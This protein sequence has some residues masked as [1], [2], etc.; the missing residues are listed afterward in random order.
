M[1][2]SKCFLFTAKRINPGEQLLSNYGGQYWAVLPIIPESVTARTYMLGKDGKVVKK[3]NA[4]QAPP[5][6]QQA[7]LRMIRMPLE[8]ETGELPASFR[9]FL[10]KKKIRYVSPLLENKI[11]E[12]EDDVLER[13][14]PVKYELKESSA[15]LKYDVYLQKT[16]K[17]IKK[18]GFPWCIWWQLVPCRSCCI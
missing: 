2:Q 9:S 18:R 4:L 10:S 7:F 17:P 15:H 6:A 1:A 3:D 11:D 16:A 8:L 14:L 5:F 12:F 13:G